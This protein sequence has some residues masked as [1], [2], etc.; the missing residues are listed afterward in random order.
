FPTRRSSDLAIATT[1]GKRITATAT[2]TGS[3]DTRQSQH[4][5]GNERGLPQSGALDFLA[6]VIFYAVSAPPSPDG[7]IPVPTRSFGAARGRPIL[8]QLPPSSSKAPPSTAPHRTRSRSA[9][10]RRGYP[11]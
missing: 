9:R 2:A 6:P 8:R 1:I 5:E 3:T 11:P 4:V 7:A 10:S